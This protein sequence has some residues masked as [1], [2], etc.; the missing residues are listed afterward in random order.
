MDGNIF[1]ME[2]V[3]LMIDPRYLAGVIDS[4]GSISINR[5]LNHGK[6]RQYRPYIQL[7]WLYFSKT[8][9]IM[10]ELK[11]KYDGSV[12]IDDKITSNFKC[13]GKYIAYKADSRKAE[14]ILID[15]LPYLK[16]K[17]EQAKCC[18]ELLRITG[19][20]GSKVPEEIWNRRK[21]LYEE[22][23]KLNKEKMDL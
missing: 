22:C 20:S 6:T 17:Q 19:Y 11:E 21:E 3:Q 23:K 7:T 10:D 8:K 16:I 15:V 2:R 5:A 13:N 18:L 14:K 4:D 9:K 1:C 12:F